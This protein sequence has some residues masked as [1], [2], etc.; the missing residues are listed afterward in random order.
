MLDA[1]SIEAIGPGAYVSRRRRRGGAH[2]PARP[3]GPG[4]HRRRLMTEK[5]YYMACLDLDGRACSS[6]A[7]DASRT[8]RSRPARLR[9]AVTVVA[10]EVSPELAALPV[11][12]VRRAVPRAPI[13]TAAASSSP[14]PPTRR[15]TGACSPTP[16]RGALL[17]RR[18]RARALLAHPP[19]RPPRG[20][21][22]RRRLDRRRLA[23]ARAAASRRYR[24]GRRPEHAE[25]ALRLRELRPW[26][27]EN[28]PTYEARRDYFAGSSEA[29]G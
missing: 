16:R 20:A 27:K 10:P 26:A 4:S 2:R 8:R 22:R 18:R 11:E 6:S 19:R 15:S 12:M 3:R 24:R 28:L 23:G 29:L 13:S 17:Q 5:H 25:L 21:D 9:R 7:A 14:R 1:S